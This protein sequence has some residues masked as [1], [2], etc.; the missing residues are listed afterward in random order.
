MSKKV[1][2]VGNGSLTSTIS[3]VVINGTD[4]EIVEVESIGHEP[5]N[6][7]HTDI[8]MLFPKLD[9]TTYKV[10]IGGS[11]KRDYKFHK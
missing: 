1:L 9:N 4:A 3:K 8:S 5:L 2:I 7:Q 6:E 10:K 11:H